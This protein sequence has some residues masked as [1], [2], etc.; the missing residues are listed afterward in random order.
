MASIGRHDRSTNIW[1]GFVDALATMLMVIMFLLLIFVVAQFY[2]GQALSGRDSALQKLEGQVTELADLL[3]LEK[4]AG[5]NARKTLAQLSQELQASVSARDDLKAQLGSLDARARDTQTRLDDAH[6]QLLA[7]KEAHETQVMQLVGLSQDVKALQALK[8]ELEIK[9][10]NLAALNQAL[11][12]SVAA[13][14]QARGGIEAKLTDAQRKLTLSKEELAAALDNLTASREKLASTEKEAA[15]TKGTLDAALEQMD[16]DRRTL[17]AEK[18]LSQSAQAQV[19]LL[20]QQMS[21]LEHALGVSEARTKEQK[22]QIVNLGKRLNAALAS[23]VQ[24]LSRYRSEF[25]GRLRDVL[26]HQQ[27]VTIVGDRFVFQSEVLFDKGSAQIG[28]AGR[29]QL[30]ALAATLKD[31][32]AKIPPKI[33][34]VLRVD[35]HTD[36]D[37]IST[38]RFPS[39]WELSSARAIAVVQQLIRDGLAPNRLVAAGFGQFQPTEARNDEIGKRRNRRIEL[40]LTQR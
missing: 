16:A 30:T 11:E 7:N 35:G 23:K 32:S 36:N 8:R 18:E 37:P 39:N 22:T 21:V 13:E 24:E 29:S 33:D 9:I 40:K 26:G 6:A 10:G 38:L 3:A 19:A 4:R 12:K 31:I 5:D 28:N 25:F 20:N 27:G 1:P 17:L 2:L 34:W 14:K 15:T